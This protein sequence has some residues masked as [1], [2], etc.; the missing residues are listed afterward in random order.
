MTFF[1]A[2][3]AAAFAPA[4]EE[5]TVTK[6]VTV[7]GP[8]L[9]I[10]DEIAPAAVTYF[11]CKTASQGTVLRSGDSGTTFNPDDIRQGD[12]CSKIRERQMDR[13]NEMLKVRAV[14]KKQRRALVEK[15]FDEIDAFAAYKPGPAPRV[16]Q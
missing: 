13:A 2:L 8:S 7:N 9:N 1:V 14:P 16:D 5:A 4:Q 3:L 11:A 15:T 12:D 6:T 10:P